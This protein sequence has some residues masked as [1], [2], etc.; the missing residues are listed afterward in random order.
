MK[1]LFEIDLTDWETFAAVLSARQMPQPVT[2]AAESPFKSRRSQR[3]RSENA[4]I[5]F[6]KGLRWPMLQIR[7]TI[8]HAENGC[9]SLLITENRA[10]YLI[11]RDF[12]ENLLCEATDP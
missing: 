1:G 2:H 3:K 11:R 10:A 8:Y 7:R 4:R 12:G 5:P 9:F 6:F